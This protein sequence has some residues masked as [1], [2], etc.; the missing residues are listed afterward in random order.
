MT[1]RRNPDHGWSPQQIKAFV[2]EV[3]N[4]WKSGWTRLG[5]T[6]RRALL[7]ERALYVCGGQQHPL[8][9]KAMTELLGD[10]LIEDG[11]GDEVQVVKAKAQPVCRHS[12]CTTYTNH[13]S[14]LCLGHQGVLC[15][16]CPNPQVAGHAPYC[17]N[18][19]TEKA[20]G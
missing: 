16:L 10:M 17:A 5:E 1:K 3:R 14:G 20:V 12:Y 11:I 7:A 9:P 4:E 2:A 13:A 15:H 18:C 8:Q 6:L 19:W